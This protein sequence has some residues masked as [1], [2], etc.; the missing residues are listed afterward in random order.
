MFIALVK[1]QS[2]VFVDTSISLLIVAKFK[3]EYITE[4]YNIFKPKCLILYCSGS[5][6]QH[7][8]IHK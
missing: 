5:V 8:S 6:L 2:A 1:I 4:N 7:L 3:S